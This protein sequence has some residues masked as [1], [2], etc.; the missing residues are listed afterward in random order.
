M[1]ADDPGDE[2][3]TPGEH[4]ET[5]EGTRRGAVQG[6]SLH[7]IIFFSYYFSILSP[8][9]FLSYIFQIVQDLVLIRVNVSYLLGSNK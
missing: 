6:E 1:A 3:G 8:P 2:E 9:I 4:R 5:E 7:I